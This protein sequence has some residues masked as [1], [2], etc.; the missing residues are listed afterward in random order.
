MLI[1]RISI[2]NF[3]SI[4]SFRSSD[5]RDVNLFVGPNDAGKS[6]ILR[7]LDLFF[8]ADRQTG[9]ELNWQRD[10]CRFA[11]TP[12]RKAPEISIELDL[13]PPPT[14]K[15]RKK[16]RWKKSWR[17]NEQVRETLKYLDGKPIE[18][19]GKIRYFVRA[20]R[21]D[22]VPAIK[23]PT[24]FAELMSSLYDMLERTVAHQVR[25]ASSAF[26]ETI[27]TNTT[28]ILEEIKERLGLDTRIELPP[29]LRQLFGQLEFTST[30]SSEPFSL[31]Q[32]GD[33]VKVRHVPIVLR[34][35][36]DQANFLSSPGKPKTATIWGYEEPENNLELRKCFELANEF[37]DASGSIQMFVTTHSPAMYSLGRDSESV[38]LFEV[39]KDI[40]P[41]VTR[42]ASVRS[43]RVSKFDGALGVLEIVE[44]HVREIRDQLRAL[45]SESIRTDITTL[46]VEGQSDESYLKIA[47]EH[48]YPEATD[49]FKILYGSGHPW[50]RD[51]ICA[52][53]YLR[54][55]AR[56]LAL[57]DSD[58]EALKSKKSAQEA[59]KNSKVTSCEK[60]EPSDHILECIQRGFEIPFSADELLPPSVW[61][62]CEANGLLERRTG[63]VQLYRFDRTDISFQDHLESRV[64]EP[65]LRRYITHRVKLS[66]K[67]QLCRKLT[68]WPKSELAAG[69]ERTARLIVKKLR[70]EV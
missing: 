23:G 20:I 47:F 12:K 5:L 50:V 35:L 26:T 60:L 65:N 33:G 4:R 13:S 66:A 51:R 1:E 34:W 2:R 3:R 39:E 32:R 62:W 44:P 17:R 11:E 61:E 63:V 45:E 41:P 46:F 69:F 6:N 53:H 29:D 42:I 38:Q 31:L 56:A 67:R 43:D 19:K 16:V 37:L 28:A 22:Y 21:Y 49:R 25:A 36:A 24:F 15:D 10:F 59:T 48:L 9:I 14:F 57:F 30:S 58:C 55:R 52:W 18:G 70:L 68:E 64:S 8:N 7:A 54:P 40:S 27:N